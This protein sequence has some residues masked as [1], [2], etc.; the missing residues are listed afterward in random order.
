MVTEIEGNKYTPYE[1]VVYLFMKSEVFIYCF[2][3]IVFV[4]NSVDELTITTFITVF[5]K[6]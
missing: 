2:G 6:M 3:R 1:Q 5:A 4:S